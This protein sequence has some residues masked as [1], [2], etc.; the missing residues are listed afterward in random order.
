MKFTTARHPY[1]RAMIE[2]DPAHIEGQAETLPTIPGRLPDLAAPP[3]GCGFAARCPIATERCRTEK[4]PLVRISDNQAALCH[5][6]T[7]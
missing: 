3:P 4:P 2:C 7:A 6:V 5:E 1:T